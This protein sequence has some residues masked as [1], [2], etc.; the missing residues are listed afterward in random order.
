MTK[1]AEELYR[2]PFGRLSYPALIEPFINEKGEKSWGCQVL[3]KPDVFS[4]ECKGLVELVERTGR[5]EFGNNWSLKT[6]KNKCIQRTDEMP[7]SEK[8]ERTKGYIC[9]KG[10]SKGP[11]Y[12]I[13]PDAKPMGVDEVNAIKGGHWGRTIIAPYTYDYL[14]NKGVSLGLRVLQFWKRD[15]EFGAGLTEALKL[16]EAVEIPVEDMPISAALDDII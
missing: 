14:G 16:A 5:A 6:A 3:V 13:G 7:M 8:D 9:I 4:K 2:T 11:V 12:V 15:E 1:K 10:N